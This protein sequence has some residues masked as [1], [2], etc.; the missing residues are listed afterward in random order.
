[1]TESQ[2]CTV[3]CLRRQIEGVHRG[4]QSHPAGAA[5]LRGNVGNWAQK[6]FLRAEEQDC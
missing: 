6:C 5:A 4:P 2:G 1:M 3:G